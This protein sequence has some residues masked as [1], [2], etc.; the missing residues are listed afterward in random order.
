ML[1]LKDKDQLNVPE[2]VI[3]RDD[4]C[5]GTND[6]QTKGRAGKEDLFSLV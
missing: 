1:K 2:V 4:S 3:A 5:S 6:I